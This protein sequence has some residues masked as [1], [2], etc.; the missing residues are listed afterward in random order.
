MSEITRGST[1]SLETTIYTERSV[2]T[3]ILEV[4]DKVNSLPD[5][6]SVQ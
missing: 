1:L 2:N 3:G 5:Y 6:K 4:G